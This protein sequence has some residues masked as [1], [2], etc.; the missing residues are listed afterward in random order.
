MGARATLVDRCTNVHG[1][2]GG[3]ARRRLAALLRGPVTVEQWNRDHGLLVAWP[4]RAATLW[5]AWMLIDARAP[6][7]VWGGVWRSIPDSFT[8][9]RAIVAALAL[10]DGHAQAEKGD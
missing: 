6:R 10:R 1:P 4:C 3:E 9:R 5:Q 8:L 7:T 2:V